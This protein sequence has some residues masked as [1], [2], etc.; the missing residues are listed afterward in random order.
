MATLPVGCIVLSLR[1]RAI[2]ARHW[3]VASST[4]SRPET[5]GPSCSEGR[6]QGKDNP[7]VQTS[8]PFLPS[9]Q[10]RKP[11]CKPRLWATPA[12]AGAPARPCRARAPQTTQPFPASCDAAP[13]GA[14]ASTALGC[15]GLPLTVT[16]GAGRVLRDSGYR[17]CGGGAGALRYF[18]EAREDG[19]AVGRRAQRNCMM[20]KER[21]AAQQQ[22]RYGT[23]SRLW[24]FLL[25][26]PQIRTLHPAIRTS[27]HTR[28]HTRTAP[29]F[30][31]LLLPSPPCPLRPTPSPHV[32]PSVRL[33]H[34][35]L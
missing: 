30:P 14:A 7:T 4:G 19:E 9:P 18:A 15:N 11:R 34:Q 27:R 31:F 16:C 33:F 10:L 23:M 6:K 22:R 25:S 1:T 20:A 29:L 5:V 21:W 12:S 32:P 26:A 2:V 17:L 28:S 13:A 24:S 35:S 3:S 8:G